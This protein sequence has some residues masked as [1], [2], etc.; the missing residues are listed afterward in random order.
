MTASLISFAKCTFAQHYHP[1]LSG[2]HSRNHTPPEVS[3]GSLIKTSG[4]TLQ[5]DIIMMNR[6]VSIFTSSHWVTVKRDSVKRIELLEIGLQ[7]TTNNRYVTFP[8]CSRFYYEILQTDTITLLCK[9]LFIN[10]RS[11]LSKSGMIKLRNDSH[12]K[13]ID[14]T[15]KQLVMLINK[16]LHKNFEADEFADRKEVLSWILRVQQIH[17]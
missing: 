15:R 2:G 8:S 1:T 10:G 17:P 3:H 11:N 9:S 13:K 14:L 5:G 4:D 6:K 7:G 16:Y 12:F